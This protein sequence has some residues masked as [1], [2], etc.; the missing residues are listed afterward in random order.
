MQG[1]S[2]NFKVIKLMLLLLTGFIGCASNP[3]SSKDNSLDEVIKQAAE[4]I[5]ERLDKGTKVALINVQSPTTQFSDYTLTYLE[6]IL[7]NNGKLIVVDR[8]NLDKI[9]QE[10]GFQLSGEVSDESAKAIGKMLGAGAIV[11]GTLINIGDSYRLTLKA[12]NVETATVAASYPADISKNERVRVLLA[13]GNMS[14]SSGTS[15]VNIV[16]NTGSTAKVFGFYP[17]GNPDN[18]III[19][20]NINNKTSKRISLPLIDSSKKYCVYIKITDDIAYYIKDNILIKP[21]TTLTFNQSDRVVL[22]S[23]T[24][25]SPSASSYKIGDTGPAGGIV[26]YDKG[27]NRDG[28]RYL[29]AAPASTEKAAPT[30]SSYD[31]NGSRKVGDGKENTKKFLEIFEKKGGGINTASWLCND[32]NTN[33]F[34]DWYLP[35]LD[36]LLYMYNNLYSKGLGGL[37]NTKYWS[38]SYHGT[39]FIDFSDGSEQNTFSQDRKYQVRAVRQF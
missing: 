34:K 33:G 4:K 24:S 20:E 19:N 5:E 21:D 6:S 14:S 36:E 32:L 8:A 23:K 28:W 15:S 16:N 18:L 2:R 31:L 9:R 37:K 29:E 12:I 27:N 26:F 13:S 25:A 17:E 1:L 22:P 7:V 30:Y 3:S 38:S 39:Y 35:S 11:T 10:Q